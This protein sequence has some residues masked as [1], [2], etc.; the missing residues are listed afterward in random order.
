MDAAIYIFVY[1]ISSSPLIMF[2]EIMVDC[3]EKKDCWRCC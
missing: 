2:F 3:G 1:S